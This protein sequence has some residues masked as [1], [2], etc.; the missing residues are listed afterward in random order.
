MYGSHPDILHAQGEQR[1][2]TA[3]G[4]ILAYQE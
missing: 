3:L 1:R 4:V 2:R